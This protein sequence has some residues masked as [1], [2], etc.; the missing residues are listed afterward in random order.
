[1]SFWIG[2]GAAQTAARAKGTKPARRRHR[3]VPIVVGILVA[4]LI[5]A[6]LLILFLANSR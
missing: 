3:I 1:M 4:V 5:V 2:I 6:G